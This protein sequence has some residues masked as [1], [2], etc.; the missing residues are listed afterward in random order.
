MAL[1]HRNG[2]G[3]PRDAALTVVGNEHGL[4]TNVQ[5]ACLD[6]AAVRYLETAESQLPIRS[7][8]TKPVKV[9][10]MS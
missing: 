2:K 10:P 8:P 6:N 7:V 1:V 9:Q 4:F 3:F 5:S